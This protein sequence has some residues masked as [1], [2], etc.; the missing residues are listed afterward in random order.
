[1]PRGIVEVGQRGLTWLGRAD[2]R[3]GKI[4]PVLGGPAQEARRETERAS[5]RGG[6][7]KTG[8]VGTR[9]KARRLEHAH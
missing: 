1:M 5:K 4:E 3:K 6:R 7:S 9:G 2:T 8:K